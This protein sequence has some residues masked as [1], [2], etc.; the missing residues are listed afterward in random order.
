MRRT[1]DQND[2]ILRTK[3][4]QESSLD[5]IL[6]LIA[7]P[8]LV[9]HHR[10]NRVPSVEHGMQLAASIPQSRLVVLE[11]EDLFDDAEAAVNA[12]GGFVTQHLAPAGSTSKWES[13]DPSETSLSRREIE[14]L[15]LLATGC[16][17][18]EIADGL[19]ISINTVRRHASNIYDKIGVAN[20]AQATIYARDHGLA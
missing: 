10:N 11:G 18:Q 2:F 16:S 1:I 6:P 4:L 7:A 20:R 8:T 3:A 5:E 15:H 12:L 13:A 14:V 19:V 17:N 9:L